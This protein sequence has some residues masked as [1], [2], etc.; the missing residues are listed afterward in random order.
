MKVIHIVGSI[1]KSAG[2]PSRSV[3][4][5]CEYVS[6]LGVE[7]ELITRPSENPVTVNTTDTYKL[8]Y[9]TLKE[10]IVFS[11]S[12]SKNEISLIHLQHVW[13]PYI[14]VIARAAQKKGIPYIITPRGMLE[15]WIMNRH[16]WKKKIAMWLYQRKDI[17]NAAYL[18]ATCDMEKENIRKLGFKNPIVVIPNGIEIGNVKQKTEWQ[19]VRNILFISRIHPKKG[20]ELLIEAIALLQN[21]QL[22]LTIAGEGDESYIAGLK[23][24]CKEKKVSEQ[25]FE[26]T[27]GVYGER[28]WELYQES[29]LFVLPT[30]SE[31][32]GIVVAEA[33]AT[34]LPVIT[35][36]GAPWQEL[37]TKKCGWWIDLD[38]QN[39]ANTLSIAMQASEEDLEVMGKNG[40][41][42][43]KNNY[44]IVNV[45]QKIKNLYQEICKI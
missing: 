8:T 44:S 20:I 11:K 6:L 30:Y 9:Y 31:N 43:I 32:F 34:G 15:P 19:K 22:K 14:H 29:D 13:D 18:H 7:I 2:G 25:Q 23:Q 42:L 41:N 12:L 40:I 38:E 10:L 35:T 37:E 26:F 4:Q 39:L 17:E 16:S 27:G 45:S 33:L 36:K 28:K 5:T 1:D 24:L 21:K 3:P